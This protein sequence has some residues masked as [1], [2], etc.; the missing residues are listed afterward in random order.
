MGLLIAFLTGIAI[1]KE[2]GRL[3]R[4]AMRQ[5][6]SKSAS[7]QKDCTASKLKG[8]KREPKGASDVANNQKRKPALTVT[9]LGSQSC[10][11]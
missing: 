9:T 3:T 7:V 10:T 8:R 5:S 11:L 6:S 4:Q 2:K 1:K